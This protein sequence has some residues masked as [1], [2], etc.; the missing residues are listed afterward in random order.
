MAKYKYK[1]SQDWAPVKYLRFEDGEEKD[2]TVTDWNFDKHPAGYLAK[3]YVTEENGE[4]TDKIWTI[5]DFEGAQ[6]LKN[7]LKGKKGKA[8]IHVKM[9]R[10]DMEQEFEISKA[11]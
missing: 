2:L 1:N 6:A 9:T 4:E 11:G 7:A 8:R 10:G 3:C 5:W